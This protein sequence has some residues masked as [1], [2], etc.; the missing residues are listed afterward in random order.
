MAASASTKCLVAEEIGS[1]ALTVYCTAG[2]RG[3]EETLVVAAGVVGVGEVGE[4][5]V[6][7][8]V[9]VEEAATMVAVGAGEEAGVAVGGRC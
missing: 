5:V 4:G 6:G 3:R 1:V 7:V 2:V 9:G 8:V